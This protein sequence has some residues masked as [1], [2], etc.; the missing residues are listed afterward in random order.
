L[1]LTVNGTPE[2]PGTISGH[3]N[4][5]QGQN[6]VSYTVPAIPT[7]TSYVWILPT[8]ATGSST[9]NSIKVNYGPS[10]VS[11]G[12]EV[13]GQNTC[14]IGNG[15]ILEI[16]V[17]SLPNTPTI[18]ENGNTLQS[19]DVNG[20]QWYNQ[21]GL[22]PDA[23][24]QDYTPSVNGNYYVI[25][26]G[27]GCSSAPSNT[28]SVITGLNEDLNKSIKIYPNPVKDE[29]IIEM[30]NQTE[31]TSYEIINSMGQIVI[32]GCLNEKTTVQTSNLASGVYLIK[33]TNG[34]TV[35]LNKIVKE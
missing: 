9:T 6:A 8:G 35:E 21:S 25:V 14:G 32:N 28:I 12:I 27:S 24:N 11:G 30:T 13:Y 16:A 31:K 29:L 15:S 34:K 2:S 33:I 23:T 5:C 3:T 19:D 7:A 22:I 20:N 26:T 10:A 4:V 1:A 17:N 18:I